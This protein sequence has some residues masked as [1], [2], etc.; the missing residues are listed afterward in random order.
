MIKI[1]TPVI[2]CFAV[3][4]TPLVG[5]TARWPEE[6]ANAWYAALPWLVGANYTPASAINQLEFWQADTFAPAEIDRELGFAAAI[7]MNSM[8]V[9]LH[10]LPWKDDPEAFLGR[11]D[12][13]LALAAKRD[14]RI[15]F[16]LLDDVWNPDPQAGPQPAPIPGRHNSGWVQSPGRA[17]LR[18]PSRWDQEVKP[19]VQGVVGRFRDDPRVLGWDVYNEPGNPNNGTYGSLEPRNKEE[20][21]LRLLEKV[22]AWVRA[23]NPS[24]PL[25]AGVWVGD[26]W[27]DPAR[28]SPLNR[29]QL[30]NSDV[31][32]FHAYTDPAKTKQ[33]AEAL[34]R[35]GRPVLC[36]EYLA[37][38][39]GSTFAGIL[40][41]F[42]ERRIA[43]YNWG[44]VAG[45]SN[46]IHAWS[47]WDRPDAGEPA[48]WF[49][50]LF[51]ADGTPFEP[52]EIALIK[53]LTRTD[54]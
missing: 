22:F 34:L 15:L 43:A 38:T 30:E 52:R 3:T 50:D 32:S 2:L 18:D 53:R 7:G 16:V 46:T 21:S 44:L 12:R 47:T 1:I 28:L 36:T 41:Y 17:I 23:M 51:R 29:F 45:K 49:H 4:M 33:R 10:D 27:T 37:R 25:T 40:P 14:M 54:D 13:F 39:A 42:H 9:Y 20:L 26:W 19:Y 5:E 8:R 31:L 6:K 24:Q 35:Y 11:I 48:V